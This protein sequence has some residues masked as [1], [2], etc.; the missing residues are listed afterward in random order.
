MNT[1][2]IGGDMNTGGITHEG[3]TDIGDG[4]SAI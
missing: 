3:W 4:G 1:G 2:G